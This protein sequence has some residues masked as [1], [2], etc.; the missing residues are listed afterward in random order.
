MN[1]QDIFLADAD[2]VERWGVSKKVLTKLRSTRLL[3]FYPIGERSI[4]YRLSDVLEYE[5][6]TGI[7]SE[8]EVML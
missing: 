7:V 6:R 1:S 8:L 4:R 5:K 2:L 3:T